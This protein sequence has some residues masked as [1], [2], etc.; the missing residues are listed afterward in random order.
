MCKIQSVAS[1]LTGH[2]ANSL[3]QQ[4]VKGDGSDISAEKGNI[5]L[6]C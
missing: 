3:G 1:D 2:K 6:S 4:A 5:S